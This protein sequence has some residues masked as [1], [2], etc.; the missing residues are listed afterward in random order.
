MKDL[1]GFEFFAY[2]DGP[3]ELDPDFG[4]E[5][6]QLYKQKVLCWRKILRNSSRLESAAQAGK[7]DD[8]KGL[9]DARAPGKP[10]VYLAECS[11]DRKPQRELLEG[12]LKRLG[13]PVL[14]DRRLPADEAE[15]VAAVESMLARCALSIHL[16]GERYGAVPDGPTDRS[17]SMIQ[18]EVAVAGCRAGSL[19]RLIWLPQG[20]GSEDDRQRKF[21]A[22]L[23]GNAEAQFGADLIAGDIEELRAAIHATL[24]KSSSRNRNNRSPAR[25]A[26]SPP[27]GTARSSS[28]SSAA[29]RTA[30]PAF[31]CGKCAGNWG[32]K[33]RSRHSRATPPR[34]ANPTNKTWPVV[35]S[36]SSF[37]ATGDEAWKRT[38]DNELKKMAGYRDAKL[39]PMPW[40]LT[41]RSRERTTSRT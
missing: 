34:F 23:H 22:A 35:A 11:F 26:S 40:R 19:K 10:A 38:I 25:P 16:V 1:I 36:W 15:F 4:P 41:W 13:Y 39:P 8:P 20:T 33:S 30:R 24:R 7:S 18:N 27:L 6:S 29:R 14:P 31:P 2:K 28:T 3:L 37:T 21:I 32:L 12:E 5:Y 9:A 17:A